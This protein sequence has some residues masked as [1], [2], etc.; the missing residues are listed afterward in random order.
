MT[1]MNRPQP[2]DEAL[3]KMIRF[4]LKTSVPRILA[5]Q[6]EEAERQKELAARGEKSAEFD[7]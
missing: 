1:T 2:S 4:L 3:R 5:K 7:C 6:A